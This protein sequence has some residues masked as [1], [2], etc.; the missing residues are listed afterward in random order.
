MGVAMVKELSGVFATTKKT[1]QQ[2]TIRGPVIGPD[3]T[4]RI[5]FGVL[6]FLGPQ[7]MGVESPPCIRKAP[8]RLVPDVRP[9]CDGSGLRG[10]SNTFVKDVTSFG[11]A[12]MVIHIESPGQHI[13][14]LG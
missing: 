13:E 12:G 8:P 9:A 4:A 11:P 14:R 3:F 6:H 5:L 1:S 10:S 7:P 2:R